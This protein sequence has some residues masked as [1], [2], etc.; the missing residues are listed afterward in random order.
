MKKSVLTHLGVR[1]GEQV[2]IAM[3][4]G[5]SVELLPAPKGK[6]SAVFGVLKRPGQPAVSLEDMND[7]IAEGWAGKR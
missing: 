5:G 2:A 3:K 1:P 4:P 6:I 7:V